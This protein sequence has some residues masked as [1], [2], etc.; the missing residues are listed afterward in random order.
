[1]A[2]SRTRVSIGPPKAA[3]RRMQRLNGGLGPRMGQAANKVSRTGGKRIGPNVQRRSRMA[4]AVVVA[5]ALKGGKKKS[6]SRRAKVAAL[7]RKGATKGERKA[8]KAALSRMSKG[9]KSKSKATSAKSSKS[10]SGSG[11]S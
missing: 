6:V 1:M 9:K 3:Q 7:A 11:N 4:R 5:G 10:G 8:A 2:L